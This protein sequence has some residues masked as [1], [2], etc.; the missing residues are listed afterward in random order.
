MRN[1]DAIWHQVEARKEPFLALSDRMGAIM[2]TGEPADRNEV[3]A[4]YDPDEAA[5]TAFGMYDGERVM[6]TMRILFAALLLFGR[7]YLL[8]GQCADINGLFFGWAEH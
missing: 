8:I 6:A 1:S 3:I 4:A 7:E 2:E 5:R